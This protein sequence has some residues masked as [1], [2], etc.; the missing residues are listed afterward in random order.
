M[1]TSD[2]L[3]E[4]TSR[5]VKHQ[6]MGGMWKSSVVTFL[7]FISAGSVPL[8]PF[9]LAIPLFQLH[10]FFVSISATAMAL[11][12]VGSA[13][14]LITKEPAL[15]SGLYMLGLGM[16]AAVVA[17]LVGQT[18]RTMG[19]I[20]EYQRGASF[21]GYLEPIHTHTATA[22]ERSLR[23]V[24]PDRHILTTGGGKCHFVRKGGNDNAS[25]TIKGLIC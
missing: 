10:P 20:S 21:K 24:F 25:R 8:V 5:Q 6:S 22:T 11:F 15:K 1:E 23:L 17:Y 2:Y 19:K 7:A 4:Q 9:I 3:G 12:M 14:S 18:S 16:T 13:R